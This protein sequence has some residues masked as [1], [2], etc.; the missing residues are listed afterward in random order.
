MK[1]INK[2]FSSCSKLTRCFALALLAASLVSG[3][4]SCKPSSDEDDNNEPEAYTA[5]PD[6]SKSC[7]AYAL[8]YYLAKT[9]QIKYNEIKDKAEDIY[10]NGD[11]QFPDNTNPAITLG[12]DS[13][14]VNCSKYSDPSKLK[15]YIDSNHLATSATLKLIST[16]SNLA[17]TI[18]I[19]LAEPSAL[20]FD[21]PAENR[22]ESFEAG[23]TGC[24]YCIEILKS[25]TAGLHYVLTYKKGDEFYTRDPDDGKEY[26]RSEIKNTHTSYEF[27]N[28]GIFIKK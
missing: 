12:S 9:E 20:N 5:Q 2:F 27:S 25:G 17:E 26:K 28:S 10:A 6:H 18:L 22:I 24:D 23:F 3:L 16:A 14:Y 19:S 13:I 8:A 4:V 21:I 1:K 15:A 7:G 11:V